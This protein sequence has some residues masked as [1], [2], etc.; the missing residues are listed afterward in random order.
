MPRSNRDKRFREGFAMGLRV[1]WL[2]VVR[3]RNRKE[4]LADIEAH[5]DE[6]LEDKSNEIPRIRDFPGLKDE[7]IKLNVPEQA[8]KD[9]PKKRS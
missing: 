1:A 4:S 6:L 3:N 2:H 5:H 7:W 9:R 8:Q